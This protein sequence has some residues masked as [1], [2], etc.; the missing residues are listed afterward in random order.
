MAVKMAV[1]SLE[2][3]MVMLGSTEWWQAFYGGLSGG[4]GDI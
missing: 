4:V 2:R 1:K 3:W